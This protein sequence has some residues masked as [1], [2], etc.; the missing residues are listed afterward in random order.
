MIKGVATSTRTHAPSEGQGSAVVERAARSASPTDRELGVSF[1]Y[2]MNHIISG[3]ND[4]RAALLV[5]AVYKS[6]R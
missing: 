2:V 3:P 5:N 1:C 6:L 4:V